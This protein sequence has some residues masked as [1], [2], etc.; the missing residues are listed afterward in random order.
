MNK[1]TAASLMVVCAIGAATSTFFLVQQTMKAQHETVLVPIVNTQGTGVSANSKILANDIEYVKV[2][3]NAIQGAMLTNGESIIG[4]YALQDMKP[5]EYIYGD[6][7]TP[8]VE[9]S[10]KE[11]ARYGA[12]TLPVDMKLAV[13]SEIKENDFVQLIIVTGVEKDSSGNAK[14]YS[15]DMTTDDL[16][17]NN[18]QTIMPPELEAV[19]VLG[20]VDNS[21]LDVNDKREAL[22]GANGQVALDATLPQACMLILDCDTTQATY[23]LQG[24]HSGVVHVKI[25]PEETQNYWRDKWGLND[26][27][28]EQKSTTSEVP[29]NNA[30]SPISQA[31]QDQTQATPAPTLATESTSAPGEETE[32]EQPEN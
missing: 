9:K 26:S 16:P 29:D 12:I 20:V 18:S 5:G 3:P 32:V 28:D 1:K 21:G 22:K 14:V 23:L 13:N 4:N 27:T 30:N 2:N 8:D 7:V 6:W 11:K 19:R 15:G 17:S 10:L 31:V 25:L 24:M